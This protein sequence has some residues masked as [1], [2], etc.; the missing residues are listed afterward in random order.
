MVTIDVIISNHRKVENKKYNV[1]QPL[2]ITDINDRYSINWGKVDQTAV[3]RSEFSIA[4]RSLIQGIGI[5]IFKNP[6]HKFR[7]I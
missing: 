6:Y 4:N 1:C 7:A 2:H 5:R 3:K